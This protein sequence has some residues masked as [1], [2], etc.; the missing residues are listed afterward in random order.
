MLKKSYAGAPHTQLPKLAVGALSYL[1]GLTNFDSRLT[2]R[3]WP[4]KDNRSQGHKKE[5][6]RNCEMMPVHHFQVSPC[7]NIVKYGKC[8]A[9]L[10]VSL[11]IYLELADVIANVSTLK[12]VIT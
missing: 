4:Q 11:C 5:R 6:E 7:L 3:K 12:Y 10:M 1:S 9:N 2:F 8:A